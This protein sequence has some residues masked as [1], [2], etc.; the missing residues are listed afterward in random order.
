MARKVFFSFHYERDVRRIVQVRNSWVVRP[1]GEA[2]PFYD[3]AEFEEAKRRAG[4]IEEWIE[5][6]L[7][8]TSV[9]VILFGAET[10]DRKWVRHEIER[11]YELKKGMLAIDIHRI[12]DP[13]KGS[14]VQGKN[15]LDYWS[16]KKNGRK[17]YFS[18]MYETYDWVNDDGYKNLSSWIEKAAKAAG[19]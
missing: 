19:R 7:K 15:P 10:Y 16:I 13:Q 4:G 3:K 14:D 8:G 6:Q 12:K 9:T 2:Q 17:V 1:E 5:Q 11:S 18:E